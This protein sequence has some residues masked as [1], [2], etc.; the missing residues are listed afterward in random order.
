V[1]QSQLATNVGPP[2]TA[3]LFLGAAAPRGFCLTHAPVFVPQSVTTSGLEGALFWHWAG[4]WW[5]LMLW[6]LG[7]L[8]A[9]ANAA[10]TTLPFVVQQGLWLDIDTRWGAK[11]G[12]CSPFSDECSSYAL[13]ELLEAAGER[14]LPGFEHA[15]SGLLG[16]H[17]SQQG[18]PLSW[19]LPNGTTLKN[20]VGMTVRARIFL[21][22]A[23]VFSLGT[24]SAWATRP[25]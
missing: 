4:L 2:G 17:A 8:R 15:N 11:P 24:G 10:F 1:E 5:G 25:V 20:P 13:V 12:A 9:P 7:G 22:D 14:V 16:L 18:Y 3:G 23:T 19:R 6:R 21:R